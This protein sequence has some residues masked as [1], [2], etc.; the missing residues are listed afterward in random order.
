[1]PAQKFLFSPS[2]MVFT[3]FGFMFRSSDGWSHLRSLRGLGLPRLEV[4]GESRLVST[5][6]ERF[7]RTKVQSAY[8]IASNVHKIMNMR[9]DLF[10]IILVPWLRYGPS[11]AAYK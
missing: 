10:Y 9:N 7:T 5:S 11:P 1:M 4:S 6:N 8:G 2:K 3:G